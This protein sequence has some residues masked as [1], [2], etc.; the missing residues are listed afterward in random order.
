M[1][2]TYYAVFVNLLVQFLPAIGV[3]TDNQ[4]VDSTIQLLFAIGTGLWVLIRRYK[5]GDITVL[6][7][8]K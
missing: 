4:A 1:S 6:G 5:Q 8:R 2:Q 3:K 7:S